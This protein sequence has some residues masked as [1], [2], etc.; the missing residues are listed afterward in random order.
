[1]ETF[2][3]FGLIV[4]PTVGGA[5]FQLGGYTLPFAVMG[6]AL[7][8]SAVLTAFVLPKYE[9]GVDRDTPSKLKFSSFHSSFHNYDLCIN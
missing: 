7:F 5:L 4:G 8:A 2:F 3:G 9:E 6:S 1:M